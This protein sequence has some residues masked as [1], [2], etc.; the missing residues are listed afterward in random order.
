MERLTQS[1]NAS[2]SVPPRPA[3]FEEPDLAANRLATEILTVWGHEVRNP[4]SALSYALQ[5]WPTAQ[6]DPVQMEELR[7]VLERQVRQLTRLSD[8]LLDTARM[9]RGQLEL[10]R[11]PVVLRQLI[12]DACEEVRPFIDRCHHTLTVHLPCEQ[13]MVSGDPSRL[14]QVFAN[15]IQN[16]AKFTNLAGCLWVTLEQEEELAVVRVRDNGPGIDQQQLPTIFGGGD[17]QQ[18]ACTTANAGLG[19]G[20]Q[21]VK[22]I[23]ELH[24]GCVVVRSEGPGHGSEFIVRLPLLNKAEC[25]QTAARRNGHDQPLPTYRIVV[26]DDVPCLGELSARLLRMLGQKV[27][28]ASHGKRAIQTVLEERP[29]VVFLDLVMPGM[30]GFEVARRL[31]RDPELTGMVLI[32][33]SGNDDEESR[34][35]A[36]EAGFDQYLVKPIGLPVLAKTLACIPDP[37]RWAESSFNPCMRPACANP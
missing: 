37:S 21:L 6:H 23:V 24:G 33:V 31:R 2:E 10:R 16:A 20:L 35:R 22:S 5:V 34:H 11:E 8:G 12:E 27:T 36:T 18:A 15:L 28:V 25:R 30:D 1:L 32:A 7:Q 26:V 17:P 29:E 3:Q 9:T 13:M 19:I 14:L 4:L